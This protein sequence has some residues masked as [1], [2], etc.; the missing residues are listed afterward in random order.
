MAKRL[1]IYLD[2]SVPNA[3]F[4]EKNLLR[5]ETTRRFWKRIG[6]YEVFVSDLVL[7]EIDDIRDE[8]KKKG[9]VTLL[10]EIKVLS[11]KEVEIK[12]LAQEYASRGII[13]V[14]HI[15]DAVHIAVA[16]F[17]SVD[18]LISWNFEHIVKLKTKREVNAIN[19]LLG[20]NQLE[21]VEPS[22]V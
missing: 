2:T 16:S 14:K 4:D 1:K 20:Y 18:V 21:I 5:K 3:Y 7:A 9:L 6:E 10:G 17:H 22:M 13:P 19:M 8:G 15:E 12:A 11:S